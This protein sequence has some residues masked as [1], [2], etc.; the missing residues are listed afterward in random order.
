MLST[1]VKRTSRVAVLLAGAVAALTLTGVADAATHRVAGE[2]VAIKVDATGAGD[3]KMRGGLRGSW[4]VNKLTQVSTSP[5]FE[6]QGTELFRG[7]IDRRRDRSCK[8]DPSG[9]LSFTIR[10]WALFGSEDPNS[11]VWGSCFHPVVKGTGD[12]KGAQGVVMMVDSPTARGVKTNYIG[13]ITLAGTGASSARAVKTSAEP[14]AA[15][16]RPGCG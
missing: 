8:G 13:T 14:S 5:Y 6:A 15:P 16:L 4:T 1:T 7:C 3:Y 12:F 2:Q 11:L 9:T 10:Y